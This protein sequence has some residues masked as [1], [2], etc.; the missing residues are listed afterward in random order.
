M[1]VGLSGVLHGLLVALL[2]ADYR[3]NKHFLNLMLLLAI[4]VKL[5]WEGAT[6]PMPGSESMAGGN[7]IVQSHLYGFVGGLVAA[8]YIFIF[9]K[10]KKL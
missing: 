8:I 10:N 2:I 3:M 5:V 6:G 4:V 9:N 1:Y 7:I